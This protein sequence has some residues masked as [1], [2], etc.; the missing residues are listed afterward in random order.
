MENTIVTILPEREQT[1]VLAVR[2]GQEIFKAV[3]PSAG[4]AHPDAVRRLLEGL[5]LWLQ[6]RLCVVVSVEES[7]SSCDALGLCDQLGIGLKQLHFEATVVTRRRRRSP[8]PLRLNGLGD[9]RA[10]RK[11]ALEGGL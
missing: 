4:V 8:R 9:F 1:R 3:L 11:L 10:L 5:A 6:C 2:D 7:E